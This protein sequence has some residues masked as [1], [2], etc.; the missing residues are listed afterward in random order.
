M[1][2]CGCADWHAHVCESV[3]LTRS[4]SHF[5]R[6]SLSLSSHAQVAWLTSELQ[7]PAHLCPS[8]PCTQVTEACHCSSLSQGGN[9]ALDANIHAVQSTSSSTEP[10]SQSLIHSLESRPIIFP[11]LLACIHEKNSF[12]V[13]YIRKKEKKINTLMNCN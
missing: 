3:F 1:H 5:W 2:I 10:S 6:Q 4:S 12:R 8:S 13:L 11:L 9:G 7:E